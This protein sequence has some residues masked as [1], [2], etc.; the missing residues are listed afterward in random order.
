MGDGFFPLVEYHKARGNWGIGTDSHYSTSISEE[1]RI[2]EC[3]KRLELR[4][5]NVI[6]EPDGDAEV[7]TGRIHF[8]TALKGGELSSRQG[9]GALVP[10]R[11]ADLVML[12]PNA[13]VFLGHTSRTVLDAWMLGGTENPVRDVMVAGNWVIRNGHHPQQDTVRQDYQ[14]AMKRLTS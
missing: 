11:R 5:R 10:G 12:D 6:A 8:D 9:G 3:G 7:H 2:L 4:R 13:D 1:L 14:A